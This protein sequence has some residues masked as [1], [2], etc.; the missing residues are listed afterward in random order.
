[1][2][3]RRPPTGTLSA[4]E[5]NCPADCFDSSHWH[6][7]PPLVDAGGSF[8]MASHQSRKLEHGCMQNRGQQLPDGACRVLTM[9]L[10]L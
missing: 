1:M 4:L 5:T 2:V 7:A 6:Q 10:G 8:A 9:T 3:G